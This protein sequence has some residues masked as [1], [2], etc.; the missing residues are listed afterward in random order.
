ME[1]ET[2]TGEVHSLYRYRQY[3]GKIMSKH[4]ACRRKKCLLER[5]LTARLNWIVSTKTYIGDRP[6]TCAIG[7]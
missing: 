7:T 6:E 3:T 1:S 5:V 4:D 2:C